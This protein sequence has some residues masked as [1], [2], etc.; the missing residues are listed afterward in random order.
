[1]LPAPPVLLITDRTQARAPLAEVAASAFAGGL[2]WLSVR[3]KDLSEAEQMALV[4]QMKAQAT[5]FQARVLLHGTPALALAAEAD[6]VHLAAGTDAGSARALLGAKALIGQSVHTL[7][8]AAAVDPALVDY[9]VAGPAFE[10]ASKPG[11]GPAL[12][13]AGLAALVGACRVPLLALGGI[14]RATIAPC[15]R[16]G[17]AGVAVMGGIMRAPDPRAE[18]EALVAAWGLVGDRGPAARRGKAPRH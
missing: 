13:E 5:R 4:A 8:E 11:Y 12:G 1:M 7:A 17:V 15:R 2:R 18:A 6:G 9:V 16:A 14:D 10:T 3:E